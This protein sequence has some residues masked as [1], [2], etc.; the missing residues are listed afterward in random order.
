MDL[1]RINQQLVASTY[2]RASKSNYFEGQTVYGKAEQILSDKAAVIRVGNETFVAQVNVSLEE[3]QSYVFEVKKASNEQIVLTIKN[4]EFSKN[5]SPKMVEDMGKFL[6]ET[7]VGKFL[8]KNNIP[9]TR[10]LFETL[11]QIEPQ[12][13]LVSILETMN[14]LSIPFSKQNIMDIQAFLLGGA[15]DNNIDEI[16]TIISRLPLSVSNKELLNTELKALSVQIN[17]R[18]TNLGSIVGDQLKI[19]S[20]VADKSTTIQQLPLQVAVTTQ[21]NDMNALTS[22]NT[23]SLKLKSENMEIPNKII[24]QLTQYQSQLKEQLGKIQSFNQTSNNT[25]QFTKL[26]AFIQ[27]VDEMRLNLGLVQNKNITETAKNDILIRHEML[28]T[29]LSLQGSVLVQALNKGDAKSNDANEVYQFVQK[30]VQNILK[31]PEISMLNEN[32]KDTEPWVLQFKNSIEKLFQNKEVLQA[33]EGNLKKII[34]E[35]MIST[36]N[37]KA[38]FE[39]IST[40]SS[41]YQAL[42]TISKEQPQYSFYLPLQIPIEGENFSSQL[43][44]RFEGK[45][46]KEGQLH[47][48]FC[49]I[50]FF[51]EMPHLQNIGVDVSFQD[52]SVRIKIISSIENLQSYGESIQEK[53]DKVLYEK[54]YKN[55]SWKYE[56]FPIE[57]ANSKIKEEWMQP[58][59]T[60][61]DVTI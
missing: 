8:V 40:A 6:Q 41:K 55:I 25:E 27:N 59:R 1:S 17:L 22:V 32:Q 47:P 33:F 37:T 36:Q 44:I 45:R 39:E 54:N 26:Q 49:T 3:G 53:I 61:V 34:D 13:Q 43:H 7:L 5:L 4:D 52:Q 42:A 56:S 29:S 28:L 60:G 30:T 48:R 18:G 50:F 24:E 15:V 12:K 38:L 57:K 20:T 11:K 2:A 9:L 31:I 19:K 46:A 10:E 21:K 35:Q 23:N 51:L 58:P 16:Q 14:K